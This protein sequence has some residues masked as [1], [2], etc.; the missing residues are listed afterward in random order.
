MTVGFK[1]VFDTG[2]SGRGAWAGGFGYRLARLFQPLGRYPD[3]LAGS[4]IGAFTA[5]DLATGDPE[6]LYKSWSNWHPDIPVDVPIGPEE[7]G[8]YGLFT[9]RKT[10]KKS[11][12]FTL[13]PATED[14]LFDPA[15][16]IRLFMTTSALRLPGGGG[17][18]NWQLWQMFLQVITRERRHKYIPR[19]IGYAPRV[20]V[21][22]VPEDAGPLSRPLTRGNV[23]DILMATCLLPLIMG[24]P[25]PLE[26]AH[27]V[28]G[29]FIRKV[30][31]SFAG[32][33]GGAALDHAAAARQTLVIANNAAG[34]L[35]KTSMRLEAWND[36]PWFRADVAEGRLL[37]AHPAAKLR[38]STVTRDPVRTMY[39]FDQGQE[40]AE[41][42]LRE[43]GTRRF[44][45]I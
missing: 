13:D 22:G 3:V 23:R 36:E 45:E 25:V 18:S 34:R 42:F 35:W 41:A 28:D 11:I 17:A 37:V 1:W 32:W 21:R 20:F 4:S 10:V 30:P 16:P 14:Q 8:F 31:L 5:M 6:V 26:G 24:H 15:N 27:L 2:G 12:H 38:I 9:F 7:R 44:F 33:D 39:F 43:Q 40:S 19:R 29:G